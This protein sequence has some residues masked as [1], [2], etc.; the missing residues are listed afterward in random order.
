MDKLLTDIGDD[1]QTLFAETSDKAQILK[2]SVNENVQTTI[3][4]LKTA[5]K[6]TEGQPDNIMNKAKLYILD[7]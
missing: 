6:K 5:V 4:T 2:K 1:Y 7:E 3:D